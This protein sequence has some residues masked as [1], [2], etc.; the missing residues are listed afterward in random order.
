[1]FDLPSAGGNIT[2]DLQY[3]LSLKWMNGSFNMAIGIVM[4]DLIKSEM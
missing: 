3:I 4:Q 1:V 2:F